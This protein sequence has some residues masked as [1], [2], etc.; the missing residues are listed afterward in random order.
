MSKSDKSLVCS[1]NAWMQ[2]YGSV[3]GDREVEGSS[4][5]RSKV[6]IEYY[7]TYNQIDC[8]D[9]RRQQH[10]RESDSATVKQLDTE[11]VDRNQRG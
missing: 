10:H 11:E 6:P 8:G 5:E 7:V 3:S 2:R 1:V 4:D 9:E